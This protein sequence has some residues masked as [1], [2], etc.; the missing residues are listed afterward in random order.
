MLAGLEI[1]SCV[2]GYSSAA[3]AAGASCRAVA[4]S[5]RLATGSE[6]AILKA[7]RIWGA[8]RDVKAGMER[9]TAR[10]AAIVVRK[11]AVV[12]STAYSCFN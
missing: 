5:R 9:R 7:G 3:A 10:R 2:V 6:G 12:S 8:R 11:D 1:C 4:W